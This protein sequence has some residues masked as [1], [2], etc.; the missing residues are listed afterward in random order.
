MIQEPSPTACIWFAFDDWLINYMFNCNSMTDNHIIDNNEPPPK[1]KKLATLFNF[2]FSKTEN[3]AAANVKETA[4]HDSSS[5]TVTHVTLNNDTATATLSVSRTQN[6]VNNIIKSKDHGHA[7]QESWKQKWPWI[8]NTE[9]GMFC[10]LCEKHKKCNKFTTG[11]KN[12]RTSTLER[13]IVSVDHQHSVS[14]EAM[15]EDFSKAVTVATKKSAA[16]PGV[17]L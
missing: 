2:N 16:E 4:S 17:R 5:D 15:R 11:C 3:S 12:F 8:K 7:F 13:H 6:N 10:T 9:S 14:E 1:M